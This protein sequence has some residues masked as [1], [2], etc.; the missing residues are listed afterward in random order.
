MSENNDIQETPI[1]A[2]PETPMASSE[3]IAT[4][5]QATPMTPTVASQLNLSTASKAELAQFIETT[6]RSENWTVP[7]SSY[8]SHSL[9]VNTINY[10]R[11]I[12]SQRHVTKNAFMELIS[13]EP[14]IAERKTLGETHKTK[15][16]IE[17]ML[18]G[19]YRGK[20][21]NFLL[22]A[23]R[24]YM[25]VPTFRDENF[26]WR[27]STGTVANCQLVTYPWADSYRDLA[28]AA[29]RFTARCQDFAR[30]CGPNTAEST[31]VLQNR[32]ST[33]NLIQGLLPEPDLLD[34]LLN[35]FQDA[36]MFKNIYTN[37]TLEVLRSFVL[38]CDSPVSVSVDQLR[39]AVDN[40]FTHERLNATTEEHSLWLSQLQPLTERI[41]CHLVYQVYYVLQFTAVELGS[42][43]CGAFLTR[44]TTTTIVEAM[45]DDLAQRRYVRT[46]ASNDVV[47]AAANRH[48]GSDAVTFNPF[49]QNNV[50]S[51]TFSGELNDDVNMGF[52]SL[53]H[54]NEFVKAIRSMGD[55]LKLSTRNDKIEFVIKEWLNSA[56]RSRRDEVTG[57]P[58]SPDCWQNMD[59]SKFID[60]LISCQHAAQ[61]K[62]SDS[63]L[64]GQSL[65]CHERVLLEIQASDPLLTIHNLGSFANS[66]RASYHRLIQTH[67]KSNKLPTETEKEAHCEALITR[68]Q[69][70]ATKYGDLM[71]HLMIKLDSPVLDKTRP[72]ALPDTMPKDIDTFIDKIDRSTEDFQT[73]YNQAIELGFAKAPNQ[74]KRSNDGSTNQGTGRDSKRPKQSA[75]D[76]SSTLRTSSKPSDGTTDKRPRKACHHCGRN[77]CPMTPT[78]ACYWRDNKHPGVNTD[79]KVPWIKSTAAQ[80]YV[81]ALD[82][83]GVQMTSP[84]EVLPSK[85]KLSHFA[86]KQWDAWLERWDDY[87]KDKSA[88]GSSSSKPTTQ[89]KKPKKGKQ[90]DPLLHLA[91]AVYDTETPQSQNW[92]YFCHTVDPKAR[93]TQ[94]FLELNPYPVVDMSLSPLQASQHEILAKCLIDGGAGRNNY[95]S[96][97]MA[98]QLI[99]VGSRTLPSH[100]TTAS[101]IK[102]HSI[103]QCSSQLRITCTFF[104]EL[105]VKNESVDLVFHVLDLD[106]EYDIIL[107]NVDSQIHGLL[108]KL[109]N[110]LFG[111]TAEAALAHARSSVQRTSI[112]SK[113][114]GT[115]FL[116]YVEAS[117]KKN[118]KFGDQFPLSDLI[119]KT[120]PGEEFP[121]D[122]YSEEEWENPWDPFQKNEKPSLPTDISG[123]PEIILNI[124]ELLGEY[125]DVFSR[126][127]SDTPADVEPIKLKVDTSTWH[128]KKNA[129][130]PRPQ[131]KIRKA[132]TLRQVQLMLAQKM[133]KPSEAIYYS[134]VLLAPKPNGTW[135]FCIDYRA[136]NKC[137]ERESWPL[138]NIEAMLHRIGDARP[139]YFAVMDATKGFFQ[140]PIDMAS[141]IF[142]AFICFAGVYQWLRCP[143]GL[144]GAPGYFQRQLALLFAAA[145]LLYHGLE[146]YIDDII[147]YGNTK[148]E[149]L[150][151]LRRTFEVLRKRRITLN[152]DKCKF[153]H[154]SVEYVGHVIDEKGIDFSAAKKNRV[155]D[156]PV[157]TLSKHLKS[158]L[159]LCNYFRDHVRDYATRT[160]PL[161]NLLLNYNKYRKL[162]WTDE[163]EKAFHDVQDAV[164]NCCKRFFLH[165]DNPNYEVVLCTDAS[166]YGL[167]GYLYQRH[168]V[169]GE[170]IPIQFVSSTFSKEQLRWTTNE[171]EAYAIFYCLHKLKY[172]IRDIQF[173]LLTD[174]KNLIYINDCASDKVARWKLFT[175]EYDAMVEHL[176]GTENRVA[177]N[178]S[179]LCVLLRVRHKAPSEYRNSLSTTTLYPSA[180]LAS[181][182]NPSDVASASETYSSIS[183]QEM[184]LIRKCHNDVT[185]H[186]GVSRTTSKLKKL[187]GS[188]QPMPRLGEKVRSFIRHCDCCQKMNQL[189]IPIQTLGFT[190]ATYS[191]MER[192]NI[193]TIGPLPAD[194]HGNVYI[195]V[196]ID[197]FSRWMRLIPSKDVTAADAARLALY[198]WICD[199]GVPEV[200]LTDNGTQFVN[201]LWKAASDILGTTLRQ[202]TP[203]SK[204]ENSIV[205]RS[206]KEVTRHLRNILFDRNIE[207]DDWSLYVP[208][209]QR[210]FN[211]TEIESIK[212]SPGEIIYGNA[213]QL[214]RRLFEVT[215]EV[216]KQG[217]IYLSQYIDTL[218]QQQRHVVNLARSHQIGKDQAHLFQKLQTAPH[219]TEYSIGSYVLLEYPSNALRRGPPNK[220]MPFLEGPLKVVNTY[221]TRYSL[222][223]LINGET[224]DVHVS[225]IRPFLSSD[226]SLDNM[227]AVAIRD[228][229]EYVVEKIL[230]HTGDPKRRSTLE[231]KV[232]WQGY[233]EEHDSWEPWK[234]LRLVDKLHDYLRENNLSKLI[235][236]MDNDS[237]PPIHPVEVEAI[238][239]PDSDQPKP[240]RRRTRRRTK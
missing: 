184:K 19:G 3:P 143:M 1:P 151:R 29:H 181:M 203:Y 92:E 32:T 160:K 216:A 124:Q 236:I 81:G 55:N 170:E 82:G 36:M 104:N 53:A 26:D 142:T 220:L 155:L 23:A 37:D 162:V 27:L 141:Q 161:L 146:L 8:A 223:N 135:R 48:E 12:L 196:I 85:T 118:P 20:Y 93:N 129:G 122:I 230:E 24:Q 191:P 128:S 87:R 58:L 63:T 22:V 25:L 197:C 33:L 219:P 192:I 90:I 229:H 83:K 69:S 224:R 86:Q 31:E 174:H 153:G 50:I 95:I 193:D 107:G 200:I 237:S 112:P 198:P 7:Y 156:F 125:T 171:K 47:G 120:D 5:Q 117:Q 38:R 232:R 42:L 30:V 101:P 123:D 187:Y 163:A 221:G 51:F 214:D 159:G 195:I 205:E 4:V 121:G 45:R 180:V 166:G 77:A 164:G 43:H 179:R 183:K 210:I 72:P 119:D 157:P 97:D 227:R 217:P 150:G 137:S 168:K 238:A 62:A 15:L 233:S 103:L 56:A 80:A 28:Q 185:G 202:T 240:K 208:L 115:S 113:D 21:P 201:E 54:T 14:K 126:E 186:H 136:L 65:T 100:I 40:K 102:P 96:E 147:V 212:C 57:V 134:Q 68:M 88:S 235:P 231:F 152:P 188:K 209:V 130:H 61:R 66:L 75:S 46:P 59:N 44:K 206:N 116:G 228:H 144:K 222:Q 106:C 16:D 89:K 182:L 175:Q 169:T 194:K 70:L 94:H 234:N 139:R 176:P 41:M 239:A 52:P 211:A 199:Y 131:S 10:V 165:H 18:R 2:Q 49:A 109:H 225:R 140:T 154:S 148:E 39:Q 105:N 91:Q 34:P 64:P 76:S 60:F 99:A 173:V 215:K 204:E 71:T 35:H 158:F 218:L 17:N 67:F 178:F 110:Q 177:D 108:F 78:K 11:Y 9:D 127:L 190:A 74:P 138:P 84:P 98:E 6:S 145:G 226:T 149:F 79:P 207:V 114:R 73:V 111:S 132:E 133:I 189:R 172:L 213:I 167:G 13:S